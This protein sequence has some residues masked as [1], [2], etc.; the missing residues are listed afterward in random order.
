MLRM[1]ISLLVSPP[2]P[3]RNF[4]RPD[5]VGPLISIPRTAQQREIGFIVRD[6]HADAPHAV[7]LLPARRERPRRRR[8]AEERDEGPPV[9]SMT[10]SASANSDG[11]TVSPSALAVVRLIARSNLV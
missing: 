9:H 1:S 8:A 4:H 10:S 5:L 2:T 6:E 11:G 3:H 7:A